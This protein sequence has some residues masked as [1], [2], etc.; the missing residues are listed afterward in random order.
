MGES[1]G[2]KMGKK[3]KKTT[4][5]KRDDAVPVRLQVEGILWKLKKCVDG[6]V[7]LYCRLAK[8]EP[9]EARDIVSKKAAA[10]MRKGQYGK[11]VD[12]Y[13]RLIGFGDEDAGVY[14]NLGYCCEREG[15]DEEAEKAYKR[16]IE[17]DKNLKDALYR[18]GL[19]AIKNED[20]RAAVTYLTSVAANNEGSFDAV[21]NLAVAHDKLKEYDKAVE[22]FKKAIAI[23]PN[24]AKVHKRLGYTYDA[25]GEHQDAV[26]CFKRAT[27]LEEV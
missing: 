26:E 9:L 7:D 1:E 20:P 4:K 2:V 27:E 19:L 14:Y 24:Y 25:M 11:A 23:E 3:K 8:I 21:Y 22:N 10:L 12:Q 6:V 15:M 5:K 13:N 16:A 18:L 17:K